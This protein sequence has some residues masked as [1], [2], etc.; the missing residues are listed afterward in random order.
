MLDDVRREIGIG[1]PHV[2]KPVK[3]CVE[4]HVG[5]VHTHPFCFG[6]G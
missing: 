1:D 2:L 6:R 3:G 5:D 4:V